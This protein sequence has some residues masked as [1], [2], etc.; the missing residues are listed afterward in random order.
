MAA[1]AAP[2]MLFEA[3][4]KSGDYGSGVP[5]PTM[6]PDHGGSPG[7]LGIVDSPEGVTYT[8]T[9]ADGR[10]NALINWEIP[11]ANRMPFRTHGTVSFMFKADRAAHVGGE[12]L[13]D[14][15]GF[16]L[17]ENGMSAFA[18]HTSRVLNGAGD[19][20]DQIAISWW[21]TDG[22]TSWWHG[23][24]TLEYDQWY[25]IG[26]AWGGPSNLHEIWVCGVLEAA[27]S[28][29]LI[30][31]GVDWGPAGESA[32]NIGLGDNHRRGLDPYGSAAGVTFAN[33]RIWDEYRSQG[34]TEPCEAELPGSISGTKF[35]DANGNQAMDPGE[36]GIEGWA[37][38][39]KDDNGNNLAEMLT[40][41]NGDY[42]F[43]SLTPA[44]YQVHEVSTPGW[45][46]TLPDTGYW[47]IALSSA[48][49]VEDVD[50]GN[51]YT[52]EAL[53]PPAVPGVTGWGITA[54]AILLA[55]SI[56]LALRRRM[57]VKS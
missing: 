41:A 16:G 8:S 21:T 13:G 19:A 12:I 42:L 51:Q 32:T 30:P 39:L 15:T 9:E 25:H 7:V 6:P 22:S 44:T 33:I 52:G 35:N 17:F 48:Q 55:I 10:S 38:I 18:T 26:L 49:N 53:P 36:E 46:Q 23:P 45:T 43:D 54:A 57:F 11:V 50:F 14:N 40:D 37:I 34:D 28:I 5:V 27:D 29:G 20:D 56:P 4:L 24:V 2:G 3:S 47:E 31:W 1:S